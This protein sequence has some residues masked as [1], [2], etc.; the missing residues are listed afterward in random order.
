MRGE[1]RF[2]FRA[3]PLGPATKWL[4]IT[5]LVATLVF[6]MTESRLGFGIGDLIFT[7]PGVLSF[8][9]WRLLTFP[10]VEIEF[11]GLLL[12]LVVLYFF[13][14]YFEQNW[15]TRPFARFFFL[16]SFGAAILAVPLSFLF[17]IILPF[18]DVGVASGPGAA[19]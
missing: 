19:L 13:G 3:P 6:K 17:N 7:V 18:T 14:A 8:E 5:I 11:W 9:L 10:L 15:G 16:S 12:N 2:A 1:Q 4:C